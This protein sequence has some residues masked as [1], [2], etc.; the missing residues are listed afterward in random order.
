MGEAEFVATSAVAYAEARSALARKRRDGAFSP[1]GHREAV[2]TLDEEWGTYEV[3][4][5][6]EN[7]ARAA[8]DLAERHA[9]RGFDAIHLAS[10]LLVRAA[11]EE[12]DERA[13]ANEVRFLSFDS[14]LT[15]A[16]GKV[17]LVYKPGDE[18]RNP[19]SRPTGA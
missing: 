12:P 5:A 6:T 2:T 14:G 7:V 16:A 11:S 4:S 18:E 10:A 9:L 8:G 15:G 19:G 13:E 1:E 3:L 17:M